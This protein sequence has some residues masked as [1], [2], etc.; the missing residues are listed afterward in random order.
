MPRFGTFGGPDELLQNRVRMFDQLF[1]NP[2]ID[3]P[4]GATMLYDRSRLIQTDVTDFCFARDGSVKDSPVRDQPAPDSTAKCYKE[5][6][7]VVLAGT[8]QS[9]REGCGVR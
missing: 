1:P 4:S 5:Y 6:W 9:F 3:R 7:I 2:P 8:T